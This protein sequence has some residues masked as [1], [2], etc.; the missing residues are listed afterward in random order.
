MRPEFG[1]VPC[2]AHFFFASSAVAT[3]S[4]VRIGRTAGM[5]GGEQ[6]E[7]HWIVVVLSQLAGLL[8]G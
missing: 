1:G 6:M 5:K 3:L 8:T 2:G 4:R 7:T